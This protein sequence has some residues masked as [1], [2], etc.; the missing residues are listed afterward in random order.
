MGIDINVDM[1]MDSDLAVCTR[2]GS[3]VDGIYFIEG[4]FRVG[5]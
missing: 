5:I 3:F 1:D 2:V 4:R